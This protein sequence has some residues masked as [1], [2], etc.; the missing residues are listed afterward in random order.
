MHVLF[1]GAAISAGRRD[2]NY[3]PR[4]RLLQAGSRGATPD[5]Q[6]LACISLSMA[7]SEASCERVFSCIGQIFSDEPRCT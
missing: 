7:P 6:H 4:D 5:S 1:D 2:E 3:L